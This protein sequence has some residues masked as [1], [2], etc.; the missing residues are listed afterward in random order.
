M[1]RLFRH[2]RQLM[3]AFAGYVIELSVDRK[4]N[5]PRAN[6]ASKGVFVLLHARTKTVCPSV[7]RNSGTGNHIL[8]GILLDFAFDANVAK[9]VDMIVI[10][11]RQL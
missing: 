7:G 9:K 8:V 4:V 10:S 1:H 2:G 6:T 11:R 5:V 3:I